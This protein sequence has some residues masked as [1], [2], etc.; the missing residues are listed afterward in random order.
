[1]MTRMCMNAVTVVLLFIA[2]GRDSKFL[3]TI[4]NDQSVR[5]A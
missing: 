2:E 3:G 5:E 1:M 4:L